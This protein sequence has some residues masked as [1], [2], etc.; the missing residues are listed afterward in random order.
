MAIT[1]TTKL[2]PIIGRPVEGVY[3]PPA[4]NTWFKENGFDIRMVPLDIAPENLA[5]FLR[6]MCNSKT[7]LGCSVTYPHKQAAF[8]IAHRKTDRA[9][10]LGALNTV[11]CDADSSLTGD[12]TDGLAMVAAIRAAG[13]DVEGRSAHILGAGG[14]AGQAIA[15]ALCEAGVSKLILKEIDAAREAAVAAAVHMNWPRTEI[16]TADES[17]DILINATT[18]GKTTRTSPPF[19]SERIEEAEIVCDVI[20]GSVP[21]ALISLAEGL[22]RKTVTGN[23]MGR[24]QLVPQLEFLGLSARN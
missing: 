21:T 2:F 12:A 17:A 15:D 13:G 20:T 16:V 14:G 10:R 23:D 4:F 7:F 3:S 6:L 24:N 11:R 22:G 8:R 19:R 1:G 18:L 9:A 5:A